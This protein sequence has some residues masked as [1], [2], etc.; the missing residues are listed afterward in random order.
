MAI[1]L[2]LDELAAYLK[3]T[4]ST[5]YKLVQRREIPGHKIGKVWRFDRDEVDTQ[6]KMGVK[7]QIQSAGIT[8][9]KH[10]RQANS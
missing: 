7:K 3:L 4:K 2:D 6:I 1:W 8:E 9:L 10:E 5:L